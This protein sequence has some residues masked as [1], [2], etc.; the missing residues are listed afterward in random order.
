MTRVRAALASGGR[1]TFRAQRGLRVVDA[2]VRQVGQV[3][4]RVGGP[5]GLVPFGVERSLAVADHVQGLVTCMVSRGW[6]SEQRAGA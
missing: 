2:V 3:P 5:A 1:R 6:E 4:G